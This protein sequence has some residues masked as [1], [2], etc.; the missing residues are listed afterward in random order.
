[1]DRHGLPVVESG[2][3]TACG[4]CIEICPKNLF[5]IHGV[6]RQLWLACRNESDPDA[7]E[8]VCEV[9]CTACG[10][11]VM[12]GAEGLIQLKSNL[13]V[14]DYEKNASANRLAIERCPTG[15][16]VWIEGGQVIKGKSAKKIIRIAP[17]LATIEA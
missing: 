5:S 17:L 16:I 9:A 12:D 7:A 15:A 8:A 3:C 11:C 6:S 1:M 10:R 4:D 13:A 14:I 2:K